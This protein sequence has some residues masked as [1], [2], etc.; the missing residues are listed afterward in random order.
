MEPFPMTETEQMPER[1]ES[2]ESAT[3]GRYSPNG[4]R[5]SFLAWTEGLDRIA[6]EADREFERVMREAREALLP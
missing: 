5:S 4:A 6:R 3:N 2:P 1:T